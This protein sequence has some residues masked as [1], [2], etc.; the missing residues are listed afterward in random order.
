MCS[1]YKDKE[2]LFLM[3]KEEILSAFIILTYRGK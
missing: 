1:M 3:E 2:T